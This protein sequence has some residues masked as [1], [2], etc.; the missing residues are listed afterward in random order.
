M[1]KIR[2]LTDS[3][4]DLALETKQKLQID[5]LP[6]MINIGDES[7]PDTHEVTSKMLFEL[8]AKYDSLPKT[9]AIPPKGFSDY[10]QTVPQDE[11]V[12][13]LGIASGF[14]SCYANAVL[15]A[16]HYPNF[17]PVDSENLST[18]IGLLLIE[19]CQLRDAGKTAPEIVAE[20]EQLRKLVRVKFAIDKLDF[21]HKGGRCSGLAKFF[22]GVLRIHPIII[23]SGNKMIV[24]KKPRGDYKNALE[25]LLDYMEEDRG[26]IRPVPISVT[27]CEADAEN[28]YLRSEINKRFGFTPMT[29]HAG[30]V[31]ATHCGPHCI[32]ILYL[33]KAEKPEQ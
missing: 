11:A 24:G 10:L 5:T 29:N 1:A 14:S 20:L 21:L 26:N 7:F 16:E 33:L 31:I 32:G 8:V 2:I 15:A 28:D 12:I 13:Y 18:G 3:T 22:S 9:S 23:V 17:Y 19:A 25:V 27:S 6:L 4:A 30:T